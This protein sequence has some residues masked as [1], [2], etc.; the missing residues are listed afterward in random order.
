MQLTLLAVTFSSSFELKQGNDGCYFIDRDGTY[1]RHILNYLRSGKTPV[2]SILKMDLEEILGEAEYYGL[3]GLV[4]AIRTKLNGDD[5]CSSE[6]VTEEGEIPGSDLVDETRK[7]LCE[8]EKKLNSFLNLSDANL[9]VL[10]EA[11]SHHKEVC[12]K[13]SNF[14]LGE[15]VEMNVG[16]KI[17]TTSLKT[18]RRESESVLALMFSKKFGLKKE[19]D[20]SFF[21]DRDGT[22]FLHVL[23]CLRDGK[24][25][26]DVIEVRGLQI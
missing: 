19:D 5:G 1:F 4:K 10:D 11:I 26:E 12:T 8:V 16:G 23:N 22:F 7:E 3:V 9:K 21:I 6:N 25:L 15:N 18:L 17:F 13:L 24:I 20:G 14:H 2:P